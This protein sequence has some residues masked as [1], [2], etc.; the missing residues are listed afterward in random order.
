M[1]ALSVK[2][3]WAFLIGNSEKTVELR[4]WQTDYRGTLLIC[5]SLS[6][7]NSWVVVNDVGHQLPPGVIMCVVDLVDIIKFDTVQTAKKYYKAAWCD[8]VSDIELGTY[9][10]IFENVRHV[11]LKKQAGKLRLF[12]VDDNLIEYVDDDYD[13]FEYAKQFA[14]MSEMNENSFW[15]KYD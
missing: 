14:T 10:W 4:S 3:P 11:K 8:A 13:F 6:E 9:G 12:D 7:K 15:I 1:K 5:A 2:Q